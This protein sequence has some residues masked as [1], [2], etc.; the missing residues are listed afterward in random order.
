MNVGR[1]SSDKDRLHSD[2]ESEDVEKNAQRAGDQ[3]RQQFEAA[4]AHGTL[5]VR[6]PL[7]SLPR[8]SGTC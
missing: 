4:H 3:C 6:S 8:S 5:L 1:L 2:A 7:P